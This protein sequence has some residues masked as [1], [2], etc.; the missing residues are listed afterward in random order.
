MPYLVDTDILI[1]FFRKKEPAV[2]YLDSLGDWSLSVITGLEL[3]AGAK[4]KREV[5]EID[6]VLVIYDAIQVVPEISQLAYN[7]MKRYSKANGLDPCDALIAATAIY[8]GLKLSTKNE[9]HFKNIEA[10]E[11]E[12][13]RY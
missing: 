12:S 7:L 1:D 10:L 6:N 8:E 13:P 3:I 2:D 4:D 9:K 5:A 11:I